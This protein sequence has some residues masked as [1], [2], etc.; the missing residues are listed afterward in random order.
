MS[1]EEV[2]PIIVAEHASTRFG[3]EAILPFQYFRFLRSRGFEAW[4]VV[5]DRTR[6]ELTELLSDDADRILYAP[7]RTAP[8]L[9]VKVCDRF[10]TP[11]VTLPLGMLAHGTTQ[12]D[13]RSLVR[14]LV[15]EKRATVVHEPIPVSPKGPSLMS[16]V[17]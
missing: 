5:H 1:T 16:D 6:P 11:L 7:D 17:G 2:R 8:K 14:R 4:L 15:R 3:G 13:E 9:A 10:P 12:M